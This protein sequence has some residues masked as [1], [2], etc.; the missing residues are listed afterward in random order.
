[1]EQGCT[2]TVRTMEDAV[3]AGHLAVCEFLL[4]QQCPCSAEVCAEAAAGGHL[5]LLR[6]LHESGCPWNLGAIC[7]RAVE[8]GSIEV[9]QYLKREGAVFNEG[10]MTAAAEAGKLHICQ[11][12]RA[13][14]CPWDASA[15]TGTVYTGS[16]DA[17]RWLREQGCPCD[18]W[19]VRE[20][21]ARLGQLSI[22]LYMQNSAPPATAPQVTE[23]LHIAC[24]YSNLAAAKWLRQQG[25]EWPAVL[26]CGWSMW[27]SD[28]LQWARA[29]GCT[30]P[31]G[32]G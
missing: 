24:S 11:Y 32:S 16:V 7:A 12:L 26:P 19:S 5:E 31:I 3:V 22:L 25:A 10:V 17:L 27:K 20:T 6:C 18:I 28:V 4:A 15:C 21:A 23:L 30:S 2:L 1:M 8:S 9:L 14:Q 29:E 13:E